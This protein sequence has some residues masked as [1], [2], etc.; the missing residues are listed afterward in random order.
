MSEELEPKP[1]K[2]TSRTTAGSKTSS[3]GSARKKTTTAT[4]T[5]AKTE[6]AEAPKAP[7]KRRS[8]QKP[9]ADTSQP[10]EK[11]P[12]A[13]TLA[14]N[15]STG[16]TRTAD[17]LATQPSTAEA[18][19]AD[20][21]ATDTLAADTLAAEALAHNP[22]HKKLGLRPDS[23][24]V[25][26]TPPENDDNP[27]LPLPDGVTVLTDLDEVSTLVG[28]Y[29]YIHIFVRSRGDLAGVFAALRDRLAAG[30]SLWVSWMKQSSN[31][32][33]GMLTDMN[34]TIIR[35]IALTHGMLDVKIIT[36]DKAWSAIRL[37]HRRH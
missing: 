37:V 33:R 20:T 5:P 35:R 1:K 3:G 10:E 8:A 2:Q 27:L 23:T 34:E 25:T 36:L 6:P 13:D 14:A 31:R 9:P 4:K 11:S 22:L 32:R 18:P 12:P 15:P 16:G 24:G 28:P 19:A 7:A 17:T 30:G 21:L 26:I 29:D